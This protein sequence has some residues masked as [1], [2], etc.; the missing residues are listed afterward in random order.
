MKEIISHNITGEPGLVGQPGHPGKPGKSG[1]NG[2]DGKPGLRGKRGKR[3]KGLKGDTVTNL[4]FNASRHFPPKIN[5][6]LVAYLYAVLTLPYP[7]Y[8]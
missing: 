1:T 4:Y 5:D 2:M 6:Q 3:G 8:F 7:G